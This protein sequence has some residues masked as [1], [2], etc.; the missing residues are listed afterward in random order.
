[1][2]ISHSAFR[3]RNLRF[4]ALPLVCG[5]L[6]ACASGPSKNIS[7]I[8]ANQ[9]ASQ[10]Q[11]S[12]L[13]VVFV[14]WEH[15][16]PDCKGECPTIKVDSIAFPSLPI[17]TKLVDHGL[18][19]MTGVGVSGPPPYDTVAG[20][21]SYFW[22]TAAPRDSTTLSAKVRYSN[23]SLTVI[24]LDTW[25]YY[26]GAAHGVSATQFLNWDNSRRRVL[27]IADV[28]ESGQ[29]PAYVAALN[30]VYQAWLANDQDARRDP[31]TYRRIWPF[32]PSDNFALTDE[33]M[34]IKYDSYQ[35]A[36]YSAGQPE[37]L[38]P[39]A[40]LRGILRPQYLP[41]STS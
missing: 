41:G 28:L 9:V 13:A 6:A 36:P 33:G 11:L 19:V 16:K 38:I 37:L 14:K 15:H 5:L 3:A 32:Q 20:Y 25:Q 35:I 39:Y 17:L 30:K 29:H 1:M 10:T 18:A 8:P 24:E 31:E 2:A 26:T 21:E 22:Q 7:L 34:V 12:G 27:G 4:W 23:K 40:D